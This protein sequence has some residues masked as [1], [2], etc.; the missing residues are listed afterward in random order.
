M[1]VIVNRQHP[2]DTLHL[3]TIH[4]KK[5]SRGFKS[6][7]CNGHAT[8]PPV[9]STV[10]LIKVVSN[11]LSK[12]RRNTIVQELRLQSYSQG[13]IFHP[14]NQ[15]LI[16]GYPQKISMSTLQAAYLTAAYYVGALMNKSGAL[17]L[18]APH[19][20][21]GSQEVVSERTEI[22]ETH[23]LSRFYLISST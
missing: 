17:P 18:H 21:S 10:P 7:A 4:H 16:Q 13:H 14:L 15:I 22:L 6:G 12:V 9:Q 8:G 1:Y 2:Y 23:H 20:K 3:L 11:I 5:E 19:A